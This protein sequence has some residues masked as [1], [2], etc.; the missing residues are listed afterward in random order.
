MRHRRG[1]VARRHGPA[2]R[3][4]RSTFIDVQLTAGGRAFQ[5][6]DS[7]AGALSPRRVRAVR[8]APL[9]VACSQNWPIGTPARRASVSGLAATTFWR[10]CGRPGHRSSG[11]TGGRPSPM[12]GGGSVRTPACRATSIR[13]A[14]SP[15][16]TASQ[17]PRDVWRTTAG[18]PATSSTWATACFPETDPGMLAAVVELVHRRDVT[19]H[20][21]DRGI[22]MAY[23]TPRRPEEV[24]PYYTDIRRGRA[25]TPEQLADLVH[26]YEAIGGFRRLPELTEAQRTCSRRSSTRGRRARSWSARVEARRAHDRGGRRGPRRRR[27]SRA[28]SAWCWPRTGRRC[29]SGST[30]SGPARRPL[31]GDAVLGRRELGHRAGVRRFPRRAT[32]GAAWPTPRRDHGRVHRTLAARRILAT[33]DPYPTNSGDRAAV[34]AA[35]GLDAVVE[36]SIGWQTAGRTPEPWIG[37]DISPS[38]TRSAASEDDDGC[39]CAP[40]VSSP[41]TSRCCTTSTSRPVSA[42]KARPGLRSHRLVNDDPKVLGALAARVIAAIEPDAMTDDPGRRRRRGHRRAAA[43][44]ELADARPTLTTSRPL[45]GGRPSARGQAR[46][47]RSPACRRRRRRRRVPRPRA[48]TVGWPR[49]RPRATTHVARPDAAAVWFDGLHPI[50]DGLVLGVPG[51]RR[52]ACATSG[53]LSAGARCAPSSSRWSRGAATADDSSGADPRPVRRRGAGAAGRRAGRQ[54]LRRRHRPLQPRRRAAA[55]RAGGD[56]SLLLGARPGAPQLRRRRPDL[57]RAARRHGRTRDAVAGDGCGTRGRRSSAGAPVARARRRRR[58][59]AGRRRARRRVVLAT[60]AASPRRCSRRRARRRPRCWRRG[61]RRRRHGDAPP[62]RMAGPTARAQRLPGAQAGAAIGHGGLFRVAEVGALAAADGWRGAARVAR[63]R[64]PAGRSPRRRAAGRRAVDEVGPPRFD[65]RPTAVRVS[66]WPAA[67]PQYRPA[68]PRLAGARRGRAASRDRPSPEPATAASACRRASRRPTRTRRRRRCQVD[69]PPA[70]LERGEPRRRRG[71]RQADRLRRGS[72]RLRQRRARRL[73]RR[74]SRARRGRP[75]R[76]PPSAVRRGRHAVATDAATTTT[77]AHRRRRRRRCHRPHPDDAVADHHRPPPPPRPVPVAPPP[78][79]GSDDPRCELGSIEI[80]QHRRRRADVRG[81]PADHPRSRP[82]ALARHGDA[83][84]V[85][86]VVVA[87]HRISHNADFRHLDQLVPGDEVIFNTATAVT[88]PRA[89]TEIV[90]PDA[91]WIVDQTAAH[92]A[93]LFA[94]HPPGST[95][96]RI[97]VHLGMTRE[98]RSRVVRARLASG[99]GFLVALSLPPWGWWPLAFVGIAAVRGRP[100]GGTPGAVTR[101]GLGITSASAWMAMGMG[102]MWQLTVPGYLVA[103]CSSRLPRARRARRAHGPVAHDRAAGGTHA[104]RGG[105]LLVSCSAG[106]RWPASASRRPADRWPASPGSA[107]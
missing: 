65:L 32:C 33:G 9:P 43:A 21:T 53:L 51:R 4:W 104:G 24:E 66:R 92:T 77:T 103:S 13:R 68:P 93:T 91:M 94:C 18:T 50:P 96:Q 106:F 38:S 49:G 90:A 14:C 12:P 60:P 29:R 55:G 39:S 28:S 3:A 5:L 8:A 101:F 2:G 56:R 76:R 37:P 74:R 79:D 64:R 81:H 30:P 40:A 44:L 17:A 27:V 69:R 95:R 36:G 26:R 46:T 83:G 25:P 59:L 61:A 100:S 10:R 63:P 11:S 82:G 47:T 45:S 20:V 62:R 22:L 52:L 97:V 105:A 42:P 1:A 84:Q 89:G 78:E 107:A 35:V 48:G 58:R 15:A 23:G 31:R 80:P 85:G 98:P 86:N 57:R 16:P 6:F 71:L 54:H 7:W 67:F 99:G 19:S 70:T 41:T 72:R 34:A 75:P 73:R 87:G 88:V 102:W